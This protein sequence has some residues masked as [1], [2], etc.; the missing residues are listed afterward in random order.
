MLGMPDLADA[1]HSARRGPLL[2]I[3]AVRM[4]K[5][6]E[7]N[8][9][10]Q[11]ITRKPVWNEQALTY[12]LQLTLNRWELELMR[13]AELPQR[14]GRKSLLLLPAATRYKAWCWIS[15]VVPG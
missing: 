14:L 6:E 5:A 8:E 10:Q 15:K 12:V 11:L 1:E 9:S 7:S 13:K 4:S 2:E 3:L